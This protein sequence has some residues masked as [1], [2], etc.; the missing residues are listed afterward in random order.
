[1]LVP[2]SLRLTL[3]TSNFCFWSM[4]SFHVLR[5]SNQN[6]IFYFSVIFRLFTDPL[7]SNRRRIVVRVSLYVTA[8]F[9][10][11]S[12][13]GQQC[14]ARNEVVSSSRSSV[15]RT[16]SLKVCDNVSI[17]DTIS[18][19]QRIT[20]LHRLRWLDRQCSGPPP[21]ASAALRWEG[22]NFVTGLLT[23]GTRWGRYL[24][25]WKG[26]VNRDD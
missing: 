9:N 19:H 7:R 18:A 12:Q 4:N 16:R 10:A 14:T 21:S 15:V 26:L 22:C 3:R 5:C 13:I 17:L 11:S 1:M 25:R 6:T 20:A 23:A 8:C 24:P 2:S